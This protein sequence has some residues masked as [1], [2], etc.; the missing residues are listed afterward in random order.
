MSVVLDASVVVDALLDP[1]VE[2]AWS[3]Q[4]LSTGQVLVP[5]LLYP[6]VTRVLRRAE[7]K[8][9]SSMEDRFHSLVGLTWVSVR[10]DAYAHW[11]WPLRHDI[12]LNDACYVALA[13]STSRPLVTLDK[14]LAS[15]AKRY[16]EVLTPDD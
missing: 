8:G 2:G 4:Y 15:T 16:C 14:K 7:M 9:F 11:V 13:Q 10:F 3:R 5:D 1:G 12:S 6:E